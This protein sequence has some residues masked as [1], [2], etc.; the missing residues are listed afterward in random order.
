MLRNLRD[1]TGKTLRQQLYMISHDIANAYRSASIPQDRVREVI[2]GV[3][4][5]VIH[6]RVVLMVLTI[7]Y[8]I[9][10]TLY[11]RLLKDVRK[12]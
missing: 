8:V 10:C 7:M 1:K 5:D 9:G 11:T 12:L 2:S 6:C 3:L 4:D